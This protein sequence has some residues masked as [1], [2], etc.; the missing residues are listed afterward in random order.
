MSE[1]KRRYFGKYRGTVLNNQD[2][3]HRGRI[4]VSV[5]DIYGREEP[6]WAL[7]CLPY[8]GE[9]VGLFLI[10]PAKAW[11]WVEFEQ[12]D[13]DYPIWSGGFWGAAKE[14]PAKEGNPALKVLTTAKATIAIDDEAPSITIEL[15]TAPALTITLNSD[16]ITLNNGQGASIKLAGMTVSVNEGALEVQ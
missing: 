8:V 12:G 1:T 16:G 5:P 10:P 2:P 4:Q 14:V 9:Q 6:P 13:P 3:Q 7:P 11:V 15:R